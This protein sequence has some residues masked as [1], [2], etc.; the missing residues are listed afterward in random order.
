MFDWSSFFLSTYTYIN[1]L[2]HMRLKLV[3]H[4][5]Q[6]NW[7]RLRRNRTVLACPENEVI[8]ANVIFLNSHVILYNELELLLQLILEWI[9]I[10]TS[11]EIK[12]LLGSMPGI[13]GTSIDSSLIRAQ[14]VSR[15]YLT[16]YQYDLSETIIDFRVACPSV[17][18]SPSSQK[19][20]VEVLRRMNW[21]R[22]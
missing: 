4:Q 16:E 22:I 7:P 3:E 17:Y 9:A 15:V 1:R 14:T 12:R 10:D 21:I 19:G 6:S 13:G 20:E 2:Y 8:P 18:I 11:R 5:M